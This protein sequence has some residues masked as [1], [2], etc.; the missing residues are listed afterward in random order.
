MD[1]INSDVEFKEKLHKD[2]KEI[3][4]E[5]Y[6][7]ELTERVAD[8]LIEKYD[9]NYPAMHGAAYTKKQSECKVFFKTKV[10]GRML[11]SVVA[12]VAIPV[13]G[14]LAL[15]ALDFYINK[16][17]TM[18]SLKEQSGREVVDDFLR[19][20]RGIKASE[21]AIES[22]SRSIDYY[23]QQSIDEK[24]SNHGGK[25]NGITTND[26]YYTKNRKSYFR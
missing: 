23:T 18:K 2:M 9:G 8:G 13:L 25:L 21:T 1:K 3:H 10:F 20:N 24:Y 12:G 11:E 6:D 16:H 14:Q 17:K 15:Y 26:A 19:S 5:K 22:A 4:G 7:E